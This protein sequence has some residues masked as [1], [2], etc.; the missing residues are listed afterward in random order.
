MAPCGHRRWLA[1]GK[2]LTR[3]LFALPVTK[4]MTEVAL[5]R[6]AADTA[7]AAAM[8]RGMGCAAVGGRRAS[9]LRVAARKFGRV[10]CQ[11][12]AKPWRKTN[13]NVTRAAGRARSWLG[14]Q[15]APL[16]SSLCWRLPRAARP[17][18]WAHPA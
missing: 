6:F 1:E 11:G 2:A 3:S 9:Q 18:V 14:G 12:C 10:L 17:R 16:P 7:T 5:T 15:Q 4:V 8:A 13:S